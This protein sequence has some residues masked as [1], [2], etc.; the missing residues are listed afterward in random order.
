MDLPATVSASAYLNS[1]V[2]APWRCHG[3]PRAIAICSST[4]W[5]ACQV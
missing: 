4:S 2:E 1:I 3:Q 5:L